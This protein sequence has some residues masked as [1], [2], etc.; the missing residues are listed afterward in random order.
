[1][2]RTTRYSALVLGI[3]IALGA[4]AFAS[5]EYTSTS[6]FCNSCHEMNPYYDSWQHS[7]H[8][9]VACKTC[10]IPPGFASFVKTKAYA[11]REVYVHFTNGRAKPIM[12]TRNVPSPVC[13]SCHPTPGKVALATSTFAHAQHN[14]SCTVPGCHQRL[15]HKTVAQPLKYTDPATMNACFVCHDAKTA[16]QTCT[17]CHVAPHETLGP[18]CDGCHS[19]TSWGVN[20]WTHPFQL[21]GQH[22]KVPCSKC[23][24]PVAAGQGVS[25][26][27]PKGKIT[28]NF[29]KAPTNC[30]DCHGDHHGGLMDCARCHTPTGWV[31]ANFTHPQEGPHVGPGSQ[32]G[33]EGLPLDC[34]QCHTA[35]Y[36]T[37]SCSC[38]GNGGQGGN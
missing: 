22:Q 32:G 15:V 23:H 14:Q 11:L 34:T 20:G 9:T 18:T 21:V 17:T 33:G 5:A 1:M 35:G 30:V 4:L 27:T 24:P 8:S 6:R 38:H 31:P 37:A 28:F 29:G 16:N 13:R 12:V 26:D 10:H 2:K 25:L 36:G 3:L 19:L 7:T